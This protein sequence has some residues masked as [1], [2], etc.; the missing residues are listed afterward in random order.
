MG[1]AVPR[2]LAVVHT[3]EEFDWFA[4]FSR[5]ATTTT[6]VRHLERAQ[7]L[8]EVHR[9]RPL[10]AIDQPIAT[11][12]AAVATLRS[13]V[14]RGTAVIGAHLHPWLSPPFEETVES[15][16]SYPGNLPPALERA[17]IE[18][19][20]RT[21]ATAFDARPRIYLAGRYGFGPNTAE[22]LEE[23]GYEVDLSPSPPFDFRNDGGPDYRRTKLVPVRLGRLWQVPHTGAFVGPLSGFGAARSA[24][25]T[26]GLLGRLVR[27]VTGRTRTLERLRLSPEG[28][29]GA[30]LQRLT[31]A[32]IARGVRLFVFSFHSPSLAAGFTPYVRSEADLDRF[33]ATI[34]EYL[35]WF[36]TSFGGEG[37][38]PD[39]LVELLAAME[40][41]RCGP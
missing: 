7:E 38:D 11:D 3:E 33:L 21:I 14:M 5:A 10:Y 18:S 28:F 34:D 12:S 29:D 23:L 40:R 26:A 15:L 22:I 6:H 19:L 31:K 35:G 24:W 2:L 20:T 32:L 4:P 13:F 8:F 36:R 39:Q 16:T 27:S 41:D 1:G 9:I 25:S 37:T 17:K 30:A